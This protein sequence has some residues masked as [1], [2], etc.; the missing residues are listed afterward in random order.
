MS[1]RNLEFPRG[2]DFFLLVKKQFPAGEL[3]LR[4]VML[5][6]RKVMG[7][8]RAVLVYKYGCVTTGVQVRSLPQNPN[9]HRY[10]HM[11][12]KAFKGGRISVDFQKLSKA[13]GTRLISLQEQK[14]A[15]CTTLYGLDM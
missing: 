5:P 2:A 11:C 9:V 4:E 6:D 7:E 12:M 15:N 8:S 3:M 10:I 1:Y 13:V 14:P